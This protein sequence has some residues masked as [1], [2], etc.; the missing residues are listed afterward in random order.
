MDTIINMKKQ[1][2]KRG[3][4]LSA[5]E[6]PRILAY[7][8]ENF[9]VI[10]D[11]KTGDILSLAP[12]YDN[13]IALISQGYPSNVSR[14]GDGLIR[15]FKEFMRDSEQAREMCHRKTFQEITKETINECL[16]EIPIE[17][18]RQFIT[19]FVLNG[20]QRMSEI[21]NMDFEEKEEEEQQTVMLM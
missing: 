7:Y 10:R 9:G 15:F 14:E 19:D 13:N 8:P 6:Q 17:V 5:V 21:I 2:E 20:Q 12:N 18:N 16:D 1:N 3:Q 4:F 11:L